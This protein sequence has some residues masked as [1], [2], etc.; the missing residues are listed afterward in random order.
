MSRRRW[1]SLQFELDAL[2]R[3]D[4]EVAKAKR[5]IYDAKEGTLARIER[6]KRHLAARKAVGKRKMPEDDQP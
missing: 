4:P 6:H 3:S 1:Y 2:E 5:R